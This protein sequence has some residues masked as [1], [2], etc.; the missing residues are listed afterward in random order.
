VASGLTLTWIESAP[1]AA[2]A[3]AQHLL[4][5]DSLQEFAR[6]GKRIIRKQIVTRAVCCNRKQTTNR[7]SS[8]LFRTNPRI[9]GHETIFQGKGQASLN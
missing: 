2:E 6:L 1:R 3:V 4:S 8:L 7:Q 5:L 9:F